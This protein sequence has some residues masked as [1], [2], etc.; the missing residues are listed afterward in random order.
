LKAAAVSDLH[1]LKTRFALIGRLLDGGIDTLLI[2]GDVAAS[3]NPG[4]QQADVRKNFGSL[5]RGRRGVQV[6]AIPGNDDWAIVEETL[7]EFPEV[8]VPTCRA[9]PLSA[10]ISIVGYPFVPITPFLMKDFEKWDKESE[11]ILPSEPEKIEAALIAN[12]L[13][14][15]GFRSHGTDLIDYAFDPGDR[16]D[17]IGKDLEEIARFSDAHE[18]LFLF[19]CPPY[20]FMDGGIS[21][22]PKVHIG[23]KAI[24]AFIEDR[25]P[26]LTIHGHSHEA[27]DIAKGDFQF[28]IG[29]STG[30]SVGP[31]NDPGVLNYLLLDLEASSFER[32]QTFA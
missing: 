30:L 4:A 2:A 23:S 13:N 11:P 12:G 8:I 14:V 29:K 24:R 20:G 5:L 19:H 17:N 9:C 3:G 31:G 21:F 6:F 32:R 22:N 10:D 1:G 26:R 28:S 27:V 18:T 7:R 16:R 15:R 25:Q